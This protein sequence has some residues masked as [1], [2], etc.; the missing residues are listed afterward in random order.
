MLFVSVRC[1]FFACSLLARAPTQEGTPAA[2]A[3]P[4]V[5]WSTD[6]VATLAK[7]KAAQQP[8][9]VF[10][11]ASW[12]VPC[13]QLKANVC[14]TKEFAAAFAGYAFAMVDID[15]DKAKAKAWQVGPI[16]DLRFVAADGEELGG[17]VGERDLASLLA[18]RDAAWT[19]AG[20]VSELRAKVANAPNDGPTLLLLAEHLLQRPNKRPGIDAMTK[21]IAADPDNEAG[22]AARAQWHIIGA[23]FHPIGRASAED[24][25][26]S[27][28]RQAAMAGWTRGDAPVYVDAVNAWLQWNEAMR[29]WSERREREKNRDLP[30]AVPADAPL[31]QTLARLCVLAATKAPAADAAAD[32]VLIDGML[33]YYS[34]D[35]ATGIERLTAFTRDFPSHRWHAEGLRFLA[36]NQRLLREH[37]AKK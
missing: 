27:V 14:S 3:A 6:L 10:F 5:E 13:K 32:G 21:V 18:L 1:V 36:I 11:T 15:Q 20:R 24:L 30:L 33:H 22:L 16:P 37:A 25:A 34:G 4:A 19:S 31:R 8:T 12:C 23:G 2:P 29:Q 7:A 26:D 9:L 35:Y 28:A 17:F